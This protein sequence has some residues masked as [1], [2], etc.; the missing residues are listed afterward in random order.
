MLADRYP[1]DRERGN[2]MAVAL[3]GLALGVLIGP[4]FGGV[5][6]EFIGKSAPFIVLAIL[7]LLDGREL[8]TTLF[9]HEKRRRAMH[10]I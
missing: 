4:P 2:A 3:G 9:K 10:Q 7:A 5:L 6:Y 8:S 1:D